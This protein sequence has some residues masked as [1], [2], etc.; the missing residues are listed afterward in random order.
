MWISSKIKGQG[1][2]EI[3]EETSGPAASSSWIP[4]CEYQGVNP[5]GIEPSLNRWEAN[6]KS[7]VGWL[8]KFC[9]RHIISYKNIC[10]E[11][12]EINENVVTE[13]K[14]KINYLC[15][16]YSEKDYFNSDETGLFFRAVPDKTM[17][18]KTEKCT[19][20][21]ISKERLTI[22]ALCEYD[23]DGLNEETPEELIGIKPLYNRSKWDSC[24]F[25]EEQGLG[26]PCQTMSPEN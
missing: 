13:W 4:T 17:A 25:S 2:R 23:R 21:K 20:G 1:K 19:D 18:I 10:W 6:F 5:P 7:S 8:D 11:R 12:S 16:R 3:P 26:R 9:T 24:P 22:L 14:E 15:E